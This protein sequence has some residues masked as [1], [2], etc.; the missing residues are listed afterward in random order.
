MGKI[1]EL[2]AD[3]AALGDVEAERADA[4]GVEEDAQP[5]ADADCQRD[6]WEDL[7]LCGEVELPG[8]D[9]E[10]RGGD[11][12]VHRKQNMVDDKRRR[13]LFASL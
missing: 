1:G 6:L 4:D 7:R 12:R 10:Q 5:V 11:A 13:V 3:R 2:A 9:L 8:G